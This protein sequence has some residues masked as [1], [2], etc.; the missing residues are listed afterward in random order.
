MDETSLVSLK[1]AAD[2]RDLNY[3]GLLEDVLE[4]AYTD[5]LKPGDRVV[6]GG[7]HI[8]RH[9]FPLSNIVGKRGHVHAVEPLPW[10]HERLE[11]ELKKRHI[12]NVKQHPVA[13]S[14]SRGEASFVAFRDFPAYSGLERRQTPF[15]DAE[16]GRETITVRKVLL[17]D[18]VP[19]FFGKV[20]FIKLDLEGGEFDALRGATRTLDRSRPFLAFECGRQASGNLYGFNRED[21]FGFFEAHGYALYSI[22]GVPFTRDDWRPQSICWDYFGVPLERTDIPPR[23]PQYAVAKLA[24]L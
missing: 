16:G 12:R 7:A 3:G 21:F 11:R 20:A 10:L 4:L 2:A 8:G 5:I 17:D 9:L 6:D 1:A 23:L 15:D 13:L 19:R 24:S 22:G 18:L 14:H